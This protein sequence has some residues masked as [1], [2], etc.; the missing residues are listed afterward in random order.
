M[1]IITT[2]KNVDNMYHRCICMYGSH[3]GMYK[4]AESALWHQNPAFF[5]SQPN[6]DQLISLYPPSVM[7]MKSN[8]QRQVGLYGVVAFLAPQLQLIYK[9]A[10]D[11]GCLAKMIVN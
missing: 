3:N 8:E 1:A 11:Q 9:A 5:V 6:I 7:F 4:P 10:P 2:K